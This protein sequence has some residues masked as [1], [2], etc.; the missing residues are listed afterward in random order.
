MKHA[1]ISCFSLFLLLIAFL[2]GCASNGS[3]ASTRKKFNGEAAIDVI[4]SSPK[5]TSQARSKIAPAAIDKEIVFTSFQTA[6]AAMKNADWSTAEKKLKQTIELDSIYA[7]PYA[8][9]GIVY[10]KMEKYALAEEAF[11]NAI[12]KNER[13]AD[14][15][16]YL[17]VALRH[18]GKFRDAE[19]AY[20]DAIKEDNKYTLAYLNLGVLYDLYLLDYENAKKAYRQYTQLGVSDEKQVNAWVLDLQKRSQASN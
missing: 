3:D 4:T 12:A 6:L 5:T 18:Q 11:K 1:L 14:F 10:M 13:R 15:Y 16:N 7:A 19:K 20:K 2:S 17:G 9:L 8:N